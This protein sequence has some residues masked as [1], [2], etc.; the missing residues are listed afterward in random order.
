[1]CA[2]AVDFFN[3]KDLGSFL[4]YALLS[5]STAHFILP[6]VTSWF[7]LAATAPRIRAPTKIPAIAVHMPSRF[8]FLCFIGQTLDQ[9][10]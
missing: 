3:K 4:F 7:M 10:D 9:I 1:M 5:P 6:S 8:L 2:F